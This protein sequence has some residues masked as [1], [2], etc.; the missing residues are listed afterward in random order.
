MAPFS[1]P[2]NCAHKTAFLNRSRISPSVHPLC[3]CHVC[4]NRSIIDVYYSCSV[5]LLLGSSAN[6]CC[7]FCFLK[8]KR[9]R[10]HGLST[11]PDLKK[12]YE[13]SY[14]EWGCKIVQRILYFPKENGE[15]EIFSSVQSGNFKE[16]LL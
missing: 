11:K 2:Y 14:D 8:V 16:L 6:V 9:Q 4:R 7:F 5:L 15:K 13:P 12:V 3:L 10:I 1:F